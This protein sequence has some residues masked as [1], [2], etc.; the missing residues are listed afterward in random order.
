M[1]GVRFQLQ[2]KT[3]V[4]QLHM[5]SAVLGKYGITYGFNCNWR[6]QMIVAIKAV[7]HVPISD[8]L[9]RVCFHSHV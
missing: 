3:L 9:V 2:I 8:S 1:L 7:S 5:E 4:E 6:R